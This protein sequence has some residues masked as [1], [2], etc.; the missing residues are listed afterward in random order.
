MAFNSI[1]TKRK[2]FKSL[3]RSEAVVSHLPN[4]GLSVWRLTSLAQIDSPCCTS[5]VIE[6]N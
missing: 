3:A 5:A 4:E 2:F 6:Q 1:T